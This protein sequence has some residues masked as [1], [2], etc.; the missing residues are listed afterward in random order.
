MILQQ[1]YLSCD[2]LLKLYLD[3]ILA[4][5]LQQLRAREKEAGLP[6]DWEIDAFMAADSVNGKRE[7]IATE[8]ILR[9]LGLDVSIGLRHCC[10]CHACG[11]AGLPL[12]C[13]LSLGT[14]YLV[15]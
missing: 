13:C 5:E 9:I 12:L 10:C 2:M 15:D 1:V 7:A 3:A 6:P 11:Y 14:S 8:Y 4:E